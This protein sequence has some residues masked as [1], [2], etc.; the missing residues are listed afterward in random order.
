VKNLK[1]IEF[2]EQNI[3]YVADNCLDL[4]AHKADDQI[5]SCWQLSEDDLK[6][7]NETGV[8]WFSVQGQG[9]PPIWLGTETPFE[10]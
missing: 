1:P 10:E 6:R 9:Q 3:T 7:V 5:I 2:K 4:P 8:I